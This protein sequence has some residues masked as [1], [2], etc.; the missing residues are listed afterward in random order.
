MNHDTIKTILYEYCDEELPEAQLREVTRHLSECAECRS[1][2]EILEKASRAFVKAA[3]VPVPEG[4]AKAVMSRIDSAA[5][6]SLAAADHL[7][8]SKESRP[9]GWEAG[10]NI[11]LELLRLPVWEI[12]VACSVSLFVFSYFSLYF[13]DSRRTAVENPAALALESQG[14][15]QLLFSEREIKREDL[16]RMLPVDLSS[17]ESNAE[18]SFNE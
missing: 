14:P 9:S 12:A 17:E 11:L 4:F 6:G 7:K 8:W 3:V 16:V 15:E 10:K 5:A 2:L 13:L 1:E 18:V